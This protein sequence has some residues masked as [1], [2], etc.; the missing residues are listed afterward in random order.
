MQAV[1]GQ[2]GAPAFWREAV[3][4]AAIQDP[5]ALRASAPSALHPM[6]CALHIPC[7]NTHVDH[8]GVMR[9]D[10]GKGK[11]RV[12]GRRRMAPIAP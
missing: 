3:L 11:T 2:G 4:N 10:R 5:A 12:Q 9:R 8:V 1:P 7:A 6:R